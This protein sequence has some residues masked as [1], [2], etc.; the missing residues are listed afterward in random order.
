MRLGLIL[1]INNMMATSSCL[2]APAY[3][4]YQGN[5]IRPSYKPVRN[6]KVDPLSAGKTRP[7]FTS[8]QTYRAYKRALNKQQR[9]KQ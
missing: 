5:G 6:V 9:S 7:E 8:R 1:A 3:H 2:M 4:V